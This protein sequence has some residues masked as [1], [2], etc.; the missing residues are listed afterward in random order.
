MTDIHNIGT[1]HYS[2]N[3]CVKHLKPSSRLITS[4]HWKVSQ[5]SSDKMTYHHLSSPWAMKFQCQTNIIT[6]NT[7]LDLGLSVC[8]PGHSIFS[9]TEWSHGA[10]EAS[11]EQWGYHILLHGTIRKQ[12]YWMHTWLLYCS[13]NWNFQDYI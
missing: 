3:K 8:L 7:L 4:Q 11:S 1:T 13:C 10:L 5:V 6:G 2:S 9:L 12:F